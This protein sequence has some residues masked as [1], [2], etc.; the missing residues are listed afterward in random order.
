M[1]NKLFS[2]DWKM[3]NTEVLYRLKT[4]PF[5]G[6][7]FIGERHRML[8]KYL[9]DRFQREYREVLGSF[10]S[11]TCRWQNSLTFLS[12]EK[13][14]DC[15]SLHALFW[16]WEPDG[17]SRGIKTINFVIIWDWNQNAK[18]VC[19]KT[20]LSGFFFLLMNIGQIE[21]ATD[22][23]TLQ[24]KSQKI[25]SW[26]W[27]WWWY[28]VNALVDQRMGKMDKNVI[29]KYWARQNRERSTFLSINSANCWKKSATVA[30]D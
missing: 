12:H 3:L 24:N 10:L 6:V 11:I 16:R 5:F 8:M 13:C 22:C 1:N 7:W 28:S 20:C 30:Q 2:E 29:A 15:R 18:S 9:Q 21:E 14:D 26:I 25:K 17:F 23:A 19:L 4:C 27:D